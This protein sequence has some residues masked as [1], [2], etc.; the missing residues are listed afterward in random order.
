MKNLGSKMVQ[1]VH[2]PIPGRR[3]IIQKTPMAN[4]LAGQNEGKV[5]FH[6]KSFSGELR[7]GV[8]G[9]EVGIIRGRY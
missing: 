1:M 9:G 4:Q 5:D 8:V 3:Q 6:A 2:N 7:S